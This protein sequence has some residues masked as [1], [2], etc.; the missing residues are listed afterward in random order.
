MIKRSVTP[1]NNA[2]KVLPKT[3]SQNLYRFK[4]DESPYYRSQ[5]IIQPIEGQKRIKLKMPALR[6]NSYRAY[7][8]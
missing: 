4:A 7:Q 5:A 1:R 6:K 3:R 8:S 2:Q